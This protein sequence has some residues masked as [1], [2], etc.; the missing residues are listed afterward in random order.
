MSSNG[1]RRF[2]DVTNG[3][4]GFGD[5]TERGRGFGDAVSPKGVTEP[6]CAGREAVSAP[7]VG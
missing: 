6:E 5:V 7:S 4:R 2:G 1:S 3:A